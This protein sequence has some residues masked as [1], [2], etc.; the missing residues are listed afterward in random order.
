[1]DGKDIS[2]P[3]DAIVEDRPG[4]VS[5]RGLVL[6]EASRQAIDESDTEGKGQGQ[7]KS[8]EKDFRILSGIGQDTDRMQTDAFGIVDDKVKGGDEKG[9]AKDD[10]VGD[11]HTVF[12]QV[13]HTFIRDF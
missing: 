11:E 10:P 8:D 7:K 9:K 13:Q 4:F 12:R 5:D 3:V 6:V 1:M 2:F